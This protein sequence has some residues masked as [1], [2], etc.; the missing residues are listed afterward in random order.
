[1]LEWAAL[2]KLFSMSNNIY[3]IDTD[4]LI[5]AYRYDF[6]PSGNHSGFWKWLNQLGLSIDLV[7]PEKVRSEIKEG[8]DG[9]FELLASLPN[10]KNQPTGEILAYIPKVLN[11]Y[12]SLTEI[13]LEIIDKWADPYVIAHAIQLNATV[14]TN[15][16]ASPGI[17]VPRKKKIPDICSAIGI[18]CVR[19]PRFLWEMR[20][21]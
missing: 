8:T 2:P 14:V 18:S 3:V 15:E 4:V 5:H 1:M 20:A 19:Y 16:I 21:L 13:D 9:L 7:V 6:P 12:G 17:I 11:A 10:L